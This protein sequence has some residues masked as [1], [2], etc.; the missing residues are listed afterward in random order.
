MKQTL[1]KICDYGCGQQAIH[2][3]KN[4][5]VCCSK[6]VFGCPSR[7]FSNQAWNKGL[8][9][10]T[11]ERV[12]RY[13]KVMK[14]TKSEKEISAWNKGLT[15]ETDERVAR[16]TKVMKKTKKGVPNYKKRKDITTDGISTSQFRYLI[17][18]RLYTSWVYPILKRD[19]FIC[20][21]CGNHNNLEVHHIKPYRKIFTEAL[22]ICN[23]DIV[24]YC[25][26]NK[27]DKMS[28]ENTVI[29]LHKLDNGITL[30]KKCHGEEDE[31]RKQFFKR[32]NNKRR[33][34]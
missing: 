8:T 34:R 28:L 14:K 18:I 31:K 12:A 33:K 3:F 7:K 10:E 29:N 25:K 16:Y 32:K 4:G 20:Q 6:Q 13:T 5:K 9:K 21:K 27:N 11:D 17:K 2:Q 15:K 22:L 19:N 1:N 30:C 23:L 26:W 24:N